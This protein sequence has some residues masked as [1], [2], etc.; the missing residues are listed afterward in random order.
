MY[1]RTVSCCTHTGLAGLDQTA[2]S[3]F[4]DLPGQ[5]RNTVNHPQHS[6]SIAPLIELTHIAGGGD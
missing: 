1:T 3:F 5:H 2:T 4:K 6:T